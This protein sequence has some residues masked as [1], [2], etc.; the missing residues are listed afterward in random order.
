MRY[1][2][3]FMRG[4]DQR[5]LTAVIGRPKRLGQAGPKAGAGEAGRA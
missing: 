3:V 1:G 5:Q 2:M 4:T